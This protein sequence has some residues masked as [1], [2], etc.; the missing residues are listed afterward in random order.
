MFKVV[1]SK[2]RR[3]AHHLLPFL[4][5]MR[6]ILCCMCPSPVRHALEDVAPGVEGVR[7]VLV[8]LVAAAED[9]LVLRQTKLAAARQRSLVQNV[10]AVGW[11]QLQ[12]HLS[13]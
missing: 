7:V 5:P 2:H 9:H 13:T 11:Q 10:P 3:K 8:Q 1:K 4:T 6:T 12:Q